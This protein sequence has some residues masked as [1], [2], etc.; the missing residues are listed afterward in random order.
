MLIEISTL[1]C[2]WRGEGGAGEG[3][4]CVCVCVC[5]TVCVCVCVSQCVCVCVCVCVCE[6]IEISKHHWRQKHKCWMK[7][8]TQHSR[9]CHCWRLWM[10]SWSA[11]IA[12]LSNISSCWHHRHKQFH[13]RQLWNTQ[14]PFLSFLLSKTN[15]TESHWPG[16]R[17]RRVSYSHIHSRS[18]AYALRRRKALISPT[19]VLRR[20]KALISPAWSLH[21]FCTTGFNAG[22]FILP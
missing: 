7:K 5:E 6:S 16:N 2:I 9:G 4:A 19:Y 21:A 18:E 22:T 20:R 15:A 10:S 17:L 8:P 12:E 14:Q 11:F 13:S 3:D 1:A